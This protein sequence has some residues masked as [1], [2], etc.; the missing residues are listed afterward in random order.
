MDYKKTVGPNLD[1]D[2][3]TD[4]EAE[5][6]GIKFLPRRFDIKLCGLKFDVKSSRPEPNPNPNPNI[7]SVIDPTI[8]R[9]D[10]KLPFEIEHLTPDKSLDCHPESQQQSI[11]FK[12][13]HPCQSPRIK[14]LSEEPLSLSEKLEDKI[15]SFEHRRKLQLQKNSEIASRAVLAADIFKSSPSSVSRNS[16]VPITTWLFETSNDSLRDSCNG[17]S[18]DIDI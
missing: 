9:K 18:E 15:R 13:Q 6:P 8:S 3:D 14:R 5:F 17:S 7:S 4:F 16:K 1:E 10:V 12:Q 11:E 2:W